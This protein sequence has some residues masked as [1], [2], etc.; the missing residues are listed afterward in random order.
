M[1]DLQP[2]KIEFPCD[3]PIKV[4]GDA[5]PDYKQFVIDTIR[6]HAPDFDEERTTLKFSSNGNFYSVTVVIVATGEDQLK[7]I[8][9]SLRVSG[10]VKMV[11]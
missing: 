8:F 1:N 5:A 6:I 2:P 9:E 7:A 10:R 3:Y 4:V 11:L